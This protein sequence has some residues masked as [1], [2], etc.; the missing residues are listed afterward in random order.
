MQELMLLDSLLQLCGRR[1]LSTNRIYKDTHLQA[2]SIAS[3]SAEQSNH[4]LSCCILIIEAL[5]LDFIHVRCL[6]QVPSFQAMHLT[7]AAIV[8]VLPL[9]ATANP[10]S[11]PRVG[12]VIPLEKRF[13]LAKDGCVDLD[14]LK[15]HLARV[16][17]CVPSSSVAAK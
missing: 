5:S 8:A 6:R 1:A 10:V 2:S 4:L 9:F 13:K 3:S 14:A 11:N 17:A 12:M 15:S 7:L 16:Q